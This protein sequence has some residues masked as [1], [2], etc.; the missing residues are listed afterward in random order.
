MSHE[1]L[2]KIQN[3]NRNRELNKKQE[4]VNQ[5]FQEEGLT[6]YILEKQI[7]INTERNKLDLPDENEFINGEYVQ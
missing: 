7:E 6:D 2:D 5:L 4:E 1:Y 3:K